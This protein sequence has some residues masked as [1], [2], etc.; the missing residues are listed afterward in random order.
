MYPRCLSFRPTD[1]SGETPAFCRCLEGHTASAARTHLTTVGISGHVIQRDYR[2]GFFGRTSTQ[3]MQRFLRSR[4]S[5]EMTGIGVGSYVAGA[6][7]LKTA[8]LGAPSACAGT[9][10]VTQRTDR[11]TARNRVVTAQSISSKTSL[12]TKKINCVMVSK[13]VF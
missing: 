13:V 8:T 9:R 10:R 5:V 3:E 4:W 2:F 1:G 12:M 11:C 7:P 6:K